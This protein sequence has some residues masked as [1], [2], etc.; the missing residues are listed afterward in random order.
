MVRTPGVVS[1]QV[2]SMLVSVERVTAKEWRKTATAGR[3][4]DYQ[5]R[6]GD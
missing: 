6:K 5:I 2:V 1:M 3:N 4:F